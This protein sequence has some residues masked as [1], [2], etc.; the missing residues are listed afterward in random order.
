MEFRHAPCPSATR[1]SAQ[2]AVALQV[3]LF[4]IYCWA[5]KDS[6]LG[7]R[8][9]SAAMPL[10]LSEHCG[11]AWSSQRHSRAGGGAVDSISNI[12]R[13]GHSKRL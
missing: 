10:G 7:R 5:H 4:L 8:R 6:N 1:R 9:Q 12:I 2:L 3:R 13:S 11:R